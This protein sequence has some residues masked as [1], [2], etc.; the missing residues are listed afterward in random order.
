MFAVVKTGGK[1]YRVAPNVKLQV[2]RLAGE[3]GDTI[4]FDEVLMLGGDEVVVGTPKVDGAVVRAEVLE[5]MRGPKVISFVK[6]RRK[7]SSQRRRGHRQHL[8]LVRI[9]EILPNG[10]ASTAKAEAKAPARAETPAS[11]PV[12]APVPE[13]IDS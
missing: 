12:A 8:T 1:Q 2:E 7:H 13:T 4:E 6:R 5:Q 3:P 9:T 11:E 10:A